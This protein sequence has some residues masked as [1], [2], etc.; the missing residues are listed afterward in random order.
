MRREIFLKR[1][2]DPLS[3]GPGAVE[4]VFDGWIEKDVSASAG[5]SR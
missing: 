3:R 2:E 5:A 4:A 1:K